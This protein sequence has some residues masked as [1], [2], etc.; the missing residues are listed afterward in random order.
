MLSALR[1][2]KLEQLTLIATGPAGFELTLKPSDLWKFWKRALP[3]AA[4]Y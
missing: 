2:R 4:L 3:L 1:Q